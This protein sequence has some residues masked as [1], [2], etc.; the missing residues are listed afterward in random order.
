MLQLS[1]A[2]AQKTELA[3]AKDDME[4]KVSE[5]SNN[6]TQVESELQRLQS[7]IDNPITTTSVTGPDQV[8]LEIIQ[9]E[10][11]SLKAEN[12][13]LNAEFVEIDKQVEALQ[14]LAEYN[15]ELQQEN[16]K[17]KQENDQFMLET[18]RNDDSDQKAIAQ[19]ATLLQQENND[20]KSDNRTLKSKVA[21]IERNVKESLA[22]KELA[23]THFSVVED[24]NAKLKSEI[25]SFKQ[26]L[27]KQRFDSHTS[28]EPADVLELKSQTS[29]LKNTISQQQ[30]TIVELMQQSARD[31]QL[32][33]DYEALQKESEVLK[34][35]MEQFKNL[36]QNQS[37]TED[38]AQ[39][40]HVSALEQE[41]MQ[42]QGY[43]MH[44]NEKLSTQTSAFSPEENN[45]VEQQLCDVQ[46][47]NDILEKDK[48]RL[49]ARVSQLESEVMA[50]KHVEKVALMTEISILQQQVEHLNMA[51]SRLEIAADQNIDELSLLKKQKSLLQDENAQLQHRIQQAEA[52]LSHAERLSREEEAGLKEENQRLW[53][54]I[55]ILEESLSTTGRNTPDYFELKAKVKQLET[56]LESERNDTV[57]TILDGRTAEQKSTE[58][59]LK[60]TVL[61]LTR[62]NERL[63]ETLEQVHRQHHNNGN[64]EEIVQI[65]NAMLLSSA[66]QLMTASR[67]G[68]NGDDHS[69]DKTKL[70]FGKSLQK[71]SIELRMTELEEE[72][73]RL[74]NQIDKL[75][76]KSMNPATQ[77]QVT[78]AQQQIATLQE[79]L[80][81]GY[82][83]VS[84]IL[85][86]H[87]PFI[88][89]SHNFLNLTRSL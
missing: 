74:R 35:S 67:T 28:T 4:V 38:G 11:L 54:Q 65:N 44:L 32:R 87:S 82:S 80:E 50:R 10:N 40:E 70:D 27:D 48:S 16:E 73:D 52:S 60:E 51:N 85:V 55:G 56:K 24:D 3:M 89:S 15:T 42:L 9:T 77:E 46:A 12:E 47:L 79:K 81:V 6:K 26:A 53:T 14:Q 8:E 31:A 76:E 57:M 41:I 1:S 83:T 7:L 78:L 33:Q 63:K 66:P 64:V 61:S 25:E 84:P 23:R 86:F 22:Q 88:L 19:L 37:N 20:L 36:M 30:E 29:H 69:N 71:R 21:E 34:S 2:I 68:L 75:I 49:E 43:N 17:L 59:S 45:N 5:L 13:R 18:K 39:A 72:N 62:E 58:I